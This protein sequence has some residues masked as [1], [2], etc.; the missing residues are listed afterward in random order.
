[1]TLTHLDRLTMLLK[2]VGRY[3]PD[4]LA[5]EVRHLHAEWERANRSHPGEVVSLLEPRARELLVKLDEWIATQ[6]GFVP[7]PRSE[8]P[9]RQ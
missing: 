5:T 6:P 9:L 2:R 1:M 7:G 8:R 3:I 4:D